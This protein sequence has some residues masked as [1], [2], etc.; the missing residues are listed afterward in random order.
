MGVSTSRTMGVSTSIPYSVKAEQETWTMPHIL[1]Y[2]DIVKERQ[3]GAINN[4][5]P[6][7]QLCSIERSCGSLLYH[8]WFV[9]DGEWFIEFA[10]GAEG[11]PCSVLVHKDNKYTKTVNGELEFLYVVH[12]EF[13]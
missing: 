12:D 10:V 11:K 2:D 9:T 6:L 13:R 4:F 5:K 8:H 1:E 3:I 7:L